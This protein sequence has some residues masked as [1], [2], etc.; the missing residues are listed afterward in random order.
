MTPEQIRRLLSIAKVLDKQ[1]VR[2][3]ELSL[4]DSCGGEIGSLLGTMAND[5]RLQAQRHL[6]RS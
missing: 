6:Q 4:I 5:L 2:A 1:A 3:D